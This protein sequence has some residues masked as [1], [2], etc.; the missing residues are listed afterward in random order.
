MITRQFCVSPCQGQDSVVMLL[1]G[2]SLLATPHVLLHTSNS[3]GH[4]SQAF[5]L[6]VS[7]SGGGWEQHVS[8]SLA[9]MIC[10]VNTPCMLA[11]WQ[12]LQHMV[13]AMLPA[14]PSPVPQH[15]DCLLLLSG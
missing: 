9:S 14:Q 3:M 8:C 6:V 12:Q 11:I 15:P 10:D 2:V 1:V 4:T 5:A 13:L 7:S